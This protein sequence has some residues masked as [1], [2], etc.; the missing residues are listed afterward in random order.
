MDEKITTI[1]TTQFIGNILG[2]TK[3]IIHSY[4]GDHVL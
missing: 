3:K 1:K 4:N 2:I